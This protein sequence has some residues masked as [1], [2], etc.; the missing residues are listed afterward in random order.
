LLPLQGPDQYAH[1]CHVFESIAENIAQNI[2]SQPAAASTV[3]YAV[4]N[5][6]EKRLCDQGKRSRRIL[7][8]FGSQ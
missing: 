6:N 4:A 3:A 2:A 1:V 7:A 5:S 8:H